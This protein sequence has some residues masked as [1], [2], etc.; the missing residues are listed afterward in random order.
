[1]VGIGVKRLL[2]VAGVQ[3]DIK[4]L[5]PKLCEIVDEG[6][7]L[8]RAH[9][10]VLMRQALVVALEGCAVLKAPIHIRPPR[11]SNAPNSREGVDRRLA[12]Q[13]VA[14]CQHIRH[15]SEPEFPKHSKNKTYHQTPNPHIPPA[16]KAVPPSPSQTPGRPNPPAHPPGLCAAA[17][18][19]PSRTTASAAPLPLQHPPH[20]QSPSTA[21]TPTY[22]LPP[23]P[24][25]FPAPKTTWA[26]AR[27]CARPRRSGGLAGS[28]PGGRP[29]SGSP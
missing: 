4:R 7:Q 25:Q 29:W 28:G 27:A 23:P 15:N 17:K 6:G 1:M 13:D 20:L 2:V 22:P 19:S 26:W 8:L 24:G 10:P 14:N 18:P 5:E 16:Q 12:V 21:G 3:N 9:A 11:N